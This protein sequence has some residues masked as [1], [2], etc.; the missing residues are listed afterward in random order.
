MQPGADIKQGSPA[1]EIGFDAKSIV[2]LYDEL[3]SIRAEAISGENK[4]TGA[5]RQD[6]E[7][8]KAIDE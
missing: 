1:I 2:K 7:I 6:S 4:L 3:E 8:F 5:Q